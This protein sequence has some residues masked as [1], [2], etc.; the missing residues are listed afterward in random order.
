MKR[1]LAIGVAGAV[2]VATVVVLWPDRAEAILLQGTFVDDNGSPHENGIEA[3]ALA[4][5]TS[6]CNPPANTRFCPNDSVT[7]AQAATF[8]TRALGLSGTGTDFF[9]DDNGHILEEGINR[10]AAVGLTVGCNPPTNNRFCPDRSLTRAEFATFIARALNLPNTNE[11][12]FVD[13]NGHVLEGP[14]NRIAEAGI[15]V[16]CNPPTNNRFCPNRVL[17]RGE[18]ATLLTRALSLPHNPQRIPLANWSPVICSKGGITCSVLVD[19]FSGRTHLVQEGFFQV[20]PYKTGEQ[21]QFTSSNTTFTLIVDGD[22][23]STT[24]LA[25][26]SSSTQALRRWNT[27]LVFSAGNHTVVGEWRW[28]GAL[29]QRTT[30]TVRAD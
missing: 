18:T 8:L 19:T 24:Q 15:T 13:D 21:A 7:R 3:L 16:G 14:I 9:V 4:Q 25:I 17:T 10:M 22:P 30:A 28:N 26:A 2:L 29:I 1:W 12:F 6:G 23:V 11:D 5:I 20:L 27:T